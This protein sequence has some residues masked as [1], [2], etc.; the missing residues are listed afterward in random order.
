VSHP[1]DPTNGLNGDPP[2]KSPLSELP[3]SCLPSSGWCENFSLN[4]WITPLSPPPPKNH[5]FFLWFQIFL[6]WQIIW[7]KMENNANSRKKGKGKG[8][9]TK[10]ES[11]S[12]D[13]SLVAND[14]CYR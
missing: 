11:K 13:V 3:P 8:K 4:S 9:A 5:H 2:G 10:S 7:E 6:I 12:V 14:N 1:N